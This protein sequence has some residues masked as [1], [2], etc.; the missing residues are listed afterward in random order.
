MS[1]NLNRLHDSKMQSLCNFDKEE[2]FSQEIEYILDVGD[3]MMDYHNISTGNNKVSLANLTKDRTEVN[4]LVD[5]YSDVTGDAKDTAKSQVRTC[6]SCGSEETVFN[7]EDLLLYCMDCHRVVSVVIDYRKINSTRIG[8]GNMCMNET[9]YSQAK[10]Q[11]HL[12]DW[13]VTIQG[14]KSPA[15]LDSV[16][17][18]VYD[19]LYKMRLVDERR[20]PYDK[21]KITIPAIQSILKKTKQ[22]KY[23]DSVAFIHMKITGEKSSFLDPQTES[24]LKTMFSIIANTY[25][26]HK[27]T[28]DGKNLTSYAYII[29]KLLELMNK[30]E[31]LDRFK[32]VKSKQ[33]LNEYNM[34]WRKICSEHGWEFIPSY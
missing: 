18:K 29:R 33:K 12:I 5:K 32:L 17:S 4:K 27:R 14:H 19:E 25:E 3:I 6:A 20:Q 31:H 1:T 26:K 22:G 10:R 13:L 30:T 15:T 11:A 34:L 2:G 24:R 16:F 21:S 23:Y 7:N 9:N 28:A 8:M